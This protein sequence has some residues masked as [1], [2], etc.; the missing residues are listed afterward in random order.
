MSNRSLLHIYCTNFP[1]TFHLHVNFS[2]SFIQVTQALTMPTTRSLCEA[3][4]TVC[5]VTKAIDVFTGSGFRKQKRKVCLRALSFLFQRSCTTA[6]FQIMTLLSRPQLPP[7]T[8]LRIKHLS[9]T[10]VACTCAALYPF[11]H[12]PRTL[13]GQTACAKAWRKPRRPKRHICQDLSAWGSD[14]RSS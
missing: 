2:T 8:C 12:I 9:T 3:R 11:S 5:Y 10:C 14:Y 6:S 4:G 1:T 13:A 7:A